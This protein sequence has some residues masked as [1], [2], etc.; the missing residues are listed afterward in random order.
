M[1][2]YKKRGG[3]AN[4]DKISKIEEES[5]TAEVFNTLDETASKSEKWVEKNSKP[6]MIGL[7]AVAAIILGYLAYNKFVIE[8]KG[9][10]AAN[11]LAY[12]KSF[13]DQAES[14]S[15]TVAVD[16]LYNLALNGADGK[17]GLIDIIDN[18]GNT[19]AGNLAKYMAGISYL[20]TSEYEKA[21]KLLSDFSTDDEILGAIAEGNIGDA[22]SQV[23]QP[24]DA[25]EHY[26][27]AANFKSNEFTT[28]L[29]LFKAGNIAM[30]M[31]NYKKAEELFAKIKN[32]YPNSDEGA[33]IDIYLNRARLSAQN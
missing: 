32:E 23:N 6:L 28:P 14:G 8:P 30:D 4:K 11:E 12:P 19:D 20:K 3:K 2:T 22:F 17:Y 13:F 15:A 25:M 1:A 29:Y 26:I 16:S 27:K 10:D 33:K 5:T 24:E 7:V 21:I 9:I 18:Y 31:G